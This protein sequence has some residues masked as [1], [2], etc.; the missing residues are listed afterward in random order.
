[1]LM[2]GDR[3]DLKVSWF[4]DIGFVLG[5]SFQDG[6]K[7][8]WGMLEIM[9][10]ID[11]ILMEIDGIHGISVN[12]LAKIIWS[13][14]SQRSRLYFQLIKERSKASS[15]QKKEFL[16]QHQL[17][18]NLLSSGV[19][20]GNFQLRIFQDSGVVSVFIAVGGW[21]CFLFYVSK[22]GKWNIGTI[23]KIFSSTIAGILIASIYHVHI[24]QK[25]FEINMKFRIHLIEKV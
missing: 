7:K 6:C 1:M 10:Q 22:F 2:K 21:N 12:G 4:C 11:E 20:N 25:Q 8:I 13:T 17:R 9:V 5:S 23:S 3:S 24:Y 18:Y 14:F 15:I 19:F 16:G